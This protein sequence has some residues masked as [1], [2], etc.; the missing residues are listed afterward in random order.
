[1]AT[2][3]ARWRHTHGAL[4]ALGVVLLL[5]CVFA[6]SEATATTDAPPSQ[7]AW[8]AEPPS[9]LSTNWITAAGWTP[10]GVPLSQL[11]AVAIAQQVAAAAGARAGDNPVWPMSVAL[12]DAAAPIFVVTLHGGPFLPWHSLAINAAVRLQAATLQVE[13]DAA[14]G[15]VLRVSGLCW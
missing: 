4:G 14:S 11:D 7:V 15:Q 6:L 5:G 12:E 2:R 9:V 1:M 10:T 13:I 3:R 8:S